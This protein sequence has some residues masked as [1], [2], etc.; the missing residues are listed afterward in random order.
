M[1]PDALVQ[2]AQDCLNRVL[3]RHFR[4]RLEVRVE[5]GVPTA[6]KV[7]PLNVNQAPDVAQP[8]RRMICSVEGDPVRR[9]VRL[10][11]QLA[12]SR[13][14][15]YVLVN[16]LYYTVESFIE[17]VHPDGYAPRD[18]DRANAWLA[19]HEFPPI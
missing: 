11:P 14:P 3:R 2:C 17:A 10:H 7:V 1:T 8:M 9:V 13:V 6:Q 18:R 12:V 15:R 19:R 5:V 4:T 16:L